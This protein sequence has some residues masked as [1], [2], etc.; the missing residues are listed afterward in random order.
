MNEQ[1]GTFTFG[2][3]LNHVRDILDKNQDVTGA[4]PGVSNLRDKPDAR[5]KGG[6]IHQHEGSLLPAIFNLI[7]QTANIP[8]A[9]DF[10][11]REYENWYNAFLTHAT[12]TAY[13]ELRPTE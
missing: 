10:V 5:L 9:I 13:E 11:E 1:L 8:M 3:I 7:D 12:G 6:S 2:Q 4:I